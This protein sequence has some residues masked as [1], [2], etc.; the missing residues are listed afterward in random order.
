MFFFREMRQVKN[1]SISLLIVLFHITLISSCGPR[2][3][4]EGDYDDP[5]RVELLDDRWNEADM[6]KMA[7]SVVSTIIGCRAVS[8]SAIRPVVL[9]DRV[10][11]RS[12]EHVDTKA[13]T[14]KIRFAL[15]NS[16][17]IRFVNKERRG[18][19]AEEYEY[20]QSGM[21]D[22][23]SAKKAGEQTGADYFLSGALHSNVQEVGGRKLIYY[24]LNMNLTNLK[25]SELDCV[26]EEE[27]RK[28]FKKKRVGL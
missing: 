28:V 8:R 14:D 21:V 9:V 15:I 7:D 4:T 16:G 18:A 24:K 3:F 10:Q 20:Q 5:N 19:I 17:K 2:A 22:P 27:I 13:L 23:V 12:M 25:T 11:N 26:A 6:Q 1:L